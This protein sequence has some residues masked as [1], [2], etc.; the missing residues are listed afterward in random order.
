MQ[1]IFLNF[2]FIYI[3]IFNGIDSK[4]SS[5]AYL[6]KYCLSIGGYYVVEDLGCS[7]WNGWSGDSRY[8][9]TAIEY[10]LKKVET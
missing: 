6:F 10:F 7:Y 8:T 2:H 3:L 1:H 5:F 9:E 4:K